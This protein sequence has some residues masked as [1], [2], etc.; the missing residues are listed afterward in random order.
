MKITKDTTLESVL[1]IKGA[2]DILSKHNVP[3]I[4][5]PFAKIEMGKLT[6]EYISKS[7]NIN[8]KKLIEDLKK[9]KN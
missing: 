3:C 2:Q 4:T 6:L 9:I 1:K 8:L 7:Y 5:C